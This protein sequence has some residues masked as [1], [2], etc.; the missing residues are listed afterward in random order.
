M[1][2][3]QRRKLMEVMDA[4]NAQLGADSVRLASTGLDRIWKAKAERLSDAK[5]KVPEAG[6][7]ADD[8]RVKRTRIRFFE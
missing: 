5:G 3:A 7:G 4:L 6:A 1:Q 2:A 8:P